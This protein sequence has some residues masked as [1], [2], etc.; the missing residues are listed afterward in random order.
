MSKDLTLSDA[1]RI[2]DSLKTSRTSVPKV[3]P[4]IQNVKSFMYGNADIELAA[5]KEKK[6]E[7]TM[8]SVKKYKSKAHSKASTIPD[9]SKILIKSDELHIG[10]E[11]IDVQEAPKIKVRTS[12]N[13]LG[14][15][16]RLR[17]LGEVI[18]MVETVANENGVSTNLLLGHILKT[19][20]YKQNR[21]VSCIG[22]KLIKLES[23]NSEVKNSK[24]SPHTFICTI[25]SVNQLINAQFVHQN[26]LIS[27]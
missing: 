3:K 13:E 10:N 26:S 27:I 12:L 21:E 11:S 8:I 15:K 5:V 20:N 7:N 1:I 16:Q 14:N 9:G 17:R 2:Y 22:D 6:I 24:L 23:G 25:I 4:Y 19:M 18:D